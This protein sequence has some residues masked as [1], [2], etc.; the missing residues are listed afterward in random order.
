MK[1]SSLENLTIDQL[2]ERYAA[3]GVEQD[4]ALGADNTAKYN[5]LFDQKKEIEEELKM[6]TR[7]STSGAHELVQL[8]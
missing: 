7:R 4:K 8:P 5:R 1:R 3:I 2:V 6:A